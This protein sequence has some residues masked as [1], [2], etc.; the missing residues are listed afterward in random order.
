MAPV[1]A[2]FFT[3]LAV[4]FAVLPPAF[5]IGG[6]G[7]AGEQKVDR[8]RDGLDVAVFLSGDIADE[9]VKRSIF[10]FATEIE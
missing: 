5:A 2:K 4:G 1:A 6:N 10:L 8:R 9:V 3:F 7:C